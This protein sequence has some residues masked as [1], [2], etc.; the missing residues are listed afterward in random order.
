MKEKVFMTHWGWGQRGKEDHSR[1]SAGN[2][3]GETGPQG[4]GEVLV[5]LQPTCCP[6]RKGSWLGEQ[7]V[8]AGG[9]RRGRSVESIGDG[10]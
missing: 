6:C 1:C 10:N 8:P 2:E 3:T 4:A 5:L 7:E 9:I